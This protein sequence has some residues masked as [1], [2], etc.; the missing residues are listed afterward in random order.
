MRIPLKRLSDLATVSYYLVMRTM[1]RSNPIRQARTQAG[2]TLA[3]ASIEAGV[4]LQAFF[5]QEQGVYPNL[6]PAVQAW[7][8][9]HEYSLP[10]ALDGYHEYQRGKRRA[11]GERL[12]LSI[13]ELGPPLGNPILELRGQLRLS[14]MGLAKEFCIHPGTLYRCET[15]ISRRL[16][17]QLR[18]ALKDGGMSEDV[19][20]DL[21]Y[22][23][24]EVG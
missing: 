22:R 16:P 18:D 20:N 13:L 12:G 7:L 14:R 24:E 4:H 15:G 19:L 11:N 21:A 23:M 3:Q 5:L 1:S 9:V 10:E 6:L 8:V 17:R 2:R